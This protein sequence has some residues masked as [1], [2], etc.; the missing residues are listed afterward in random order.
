MIMLL[1]ATQTASKLGRSSSWV[2]ALKHYGRAIGDT[3]FNIGGGRYTRLPLL[4]EWLDTHPEFIAS[5]QYRP[6]RQLRQKDL[7]KPVFDK[8]GGSSPKRAR[9]TPLPGL[10][11]PLPA[12]T[13]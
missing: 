13:S 9:H 3:P 6:T 11:V 4:L 8:H 10:P 7:M 12:P 1:D 5:H 2:Y